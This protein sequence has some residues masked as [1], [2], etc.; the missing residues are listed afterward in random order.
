MDGKNQFKIYCISFIRI[1]N[2]LLIVQ[3]QPIKEGNSQNIKVMTMGKNYK[4]SF[5]KIDDK[6]VNKYSQKYVIL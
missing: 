6:W 2:F 5:N 1:N 3:R 4:I